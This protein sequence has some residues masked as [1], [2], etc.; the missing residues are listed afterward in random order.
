MVYHQIF[1]LCPWC[2]GC[3]EAPFIT[4]RHFFGCLTVQGLLVI[5]LELI[6]LFE[7]LRIIVC[8]DLLH[9]EPFSQALKGELSVTLS[10][11]WASGCVSQN[12]GITEL[13]VLSLVAK[14]ITVWV[15]HTAF[16][17]KTRKCKQCLAAEEIQG[18]QS[19]TFKRFS[20]AVVLYPENEGF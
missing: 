9:I 14:W 5:T 4:V 8:V 13:A 6:T 12:W 10:F 11:I 3:S 1:V 16:L 7:L 18:Y 2:G 17:W 19:R 20:G 15:I